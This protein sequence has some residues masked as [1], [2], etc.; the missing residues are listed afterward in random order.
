[1]KIYTPAAPDGVEWVTLQDPDPDSWET[2]F[3]LDGPVG[4]AWRA[5]EVSFIR[6]EEDGRPRQYA[7]CPWCLHTVLIVRDGALTAL[8]PLLERYGEI[9]PLRCEEPVSLFNAT[10]ILDALDE[11]RSAIA[12]FADG[13]VLAIER[14]VFKPD[15]IGNNEIFK[16]PGRASNIYF[17][18]TAVRRIG[19]LGLRGLAFDLVWTDETVAPDES[20]IEYPA[21]R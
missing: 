11:E 16:L 14:H 18:E 8:R 15:V 3:A 13:G 6:Q 9:L 7:D 19:E 10:T 12:R 20:R 5:P 17:R 2:L 21:R 1:V 4:L